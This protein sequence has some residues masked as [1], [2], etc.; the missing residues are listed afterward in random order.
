[1]AGRHRG[2]RGVSKPERERP[3]LHLERR[4]LVDTAP[5]TDEPVRRVAQQ[6][7]TRSSVLLEPRRDVDG[8]ARDERLPGGRSP[9]TTPPV[10]TPMW[11]R[12]ANRDRVRALVQPVE[13]VTHVDRRRDTPAARRLRGAAGSEHGHHRVADVLLDRPSVALDRRAHR[14]EVP[15]HQKPQGFGVEALAERRRVDDVG[16]EH[17]DSLP[18]ETL[19]PFESRP[20]TPPETMRAGAP[21]VCPG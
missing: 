5:C 15:Q 6:D 9:A 21:G 1:M 10:F 18:G 3:A 20:Q 19:H 13:S 17:G 14:V 7:L 2:P 16:E 8:I 4:N 12:I 11:T